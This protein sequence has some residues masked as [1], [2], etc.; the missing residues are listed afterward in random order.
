[1]VLSSEDKLRQEILQSLYGWGEIEFKRFSEKAGRDFH[2][3]F[4]DELVRLKDLE[5]DGLVK[6]TPD[7]ISLT[8]RLGRLLVRVVA[9]VFDSYIPK[10][11]YRSGLTD[12]KGSRTG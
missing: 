7:K 8:P 6:I 4:Q 5:N 10:D 1:M 3:V 2:E 9:S 11:A 12:G